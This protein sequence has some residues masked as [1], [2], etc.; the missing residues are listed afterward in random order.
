M[1]NK[2]LQR[3]IFTGLMVAIGVVL[4][5]VVSISYPPNSTIIRFGI[6][7]LPLIILSILLGPKIGITAAIIQD[8]LG[9]F[10][11]IWVFGVPSGPFFP[12]FTLNSVLYGVVPGIIYNFKIRKN[13]LFMILNFALLIILMIFGIYGFFN[14]TEIIA[15][16]ENRLSSDMSFQPWIIYL[17]LALGEVGIISTLYFLYRKRTEDDSAQR[18]IFAVIILQLVVTLILTPLWVMILYKIP[19]APQLP[20]R[21]IKTPIEIFIYSILLIRIIKVFKNY[22]I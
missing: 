19:F 17:M 11:Y 15:I 10:V 12:G 5:S 14:I 1:K 16:I 13:N 6:G 3:I 9:Y 2:N 4:S 21:I 20:L 22:T 7:Y 18:I 8:V